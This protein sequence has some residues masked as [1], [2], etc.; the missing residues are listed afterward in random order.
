[1]SLNE[2]MNPD[3]IS[4]LEMRYNDESV[5]TDDMVVIDFEDS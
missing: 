3:R 5:Q 2:R 1:M 4:I